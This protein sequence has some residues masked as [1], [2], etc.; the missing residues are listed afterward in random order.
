MLPLNKRLHTKLFC[1]FLFSVL[2]MTG[3]QARPGAEQAEDSGAIFRSDTRVVDLH[4]T[5]VDKA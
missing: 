3:Q 4:A 5:V 2:A 1:G